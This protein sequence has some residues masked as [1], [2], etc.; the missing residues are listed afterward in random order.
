MDVAGNPGQLPA[1]VQELDGSVSRG[2]LTAAV[3]RAL[4]EPIR[5]LKM[6]K[7]ARR[8]ATRHHTHLALARYVLAETEA[9]LSRRGQGSLQMSG[10]IPLA[11]TGA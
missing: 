7:A 2:G 4:S 9:V 3:V 5:L 1:A 10:L 11:G 6:G 8:H